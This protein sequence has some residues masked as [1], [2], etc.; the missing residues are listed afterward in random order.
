MAWTL[1]WMRPRDKKTA[2]SEV[3]RLY[4]LFKGS[5]RTFF[6]HQTHHQYQRI[7]LYLHQKSLPLNPQALPKKKGKKQ[8]IP[9]PTRLL[10]FCEETKVSVDPL[11][12]TN[13]LNS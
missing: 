3:R 10:K 13:S 12:K 7:S 5:N 6:S 11:Q 1:E 2:S 8:I 9:S 4:R